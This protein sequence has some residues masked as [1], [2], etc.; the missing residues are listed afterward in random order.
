MQSAV[1]VNPVEQITDALKQ[2]DAPAL[3]RLIKNKVR[4][5]TRARRRRRRRTSAVPTPSRSNSESHGCR[6]SQW[7]SVN[8]AAY[9][10]PNAASP[11]LLTK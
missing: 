8:C 3:R 9:S 5:H 7:M 2:G 11:L 6:Y 10:V 1:Q 4:K